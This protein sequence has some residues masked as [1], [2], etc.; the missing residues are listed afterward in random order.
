MNI[1]LEAQHAVG[2]PQPRGVGHYA[3]SLIQ[4]LL[5]RKKFNYELTY[6]DFKREVGNFE[7]AEKLF[8]K[9]NVPMHECNELDYRIASRDDSVFADKSYNEWTNTLGDVYHF[10]VPV[11][12]PTKLNGKMIVTF[13]DVSW[14][15]F[16]GFVSPNA[17]LLHDIA[18]ERVQ[19]QN[20]YIIADSESAKKEI[21]LYSSIPEERIKVIYLSYDEEQ[22]FKD[23]SS[24]ND[25]VDG[26]YILFVGT[27]EN[28]KNVVRIIEAYNMVA[29]KN[30][31]IK[32][33]LAG[34]P[35]WDNPTDIYETI[36]NSP[37]KDRII[38]PGYI[39]VEQ[40]RKL[41]SNALCFVFPSICEGFG[42]P[43][44]EAMACGCPVITADNT[45]LPEVG[46]D[47]VIYVNAYDTEQLGYEMEHVINSSNLR[48]ELIS[49]GYIQK[50]KFSWDKTA[51]HV[52]DL[53]SMVMEQNY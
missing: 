52:E 50:S 21:L 49:K 9:Y 7:R 27:F 25:I 19:R 26:D 15:A 36:N 39:T 29:E 35:T 2:H 3:T 11:S 23:K 13:H 1:V 34:K 51:E 48:E 6:F 4:T 18:L 42:I 24:V 41:Y 5:K 44:L 17:T 31:S 12:I 53:Y 46:G 33:V 40:K 30:K 8:G 38:T 16:P 14:R 37:Y 47:A 32:L 28:K 22:I 43:V 45:S 20:P 10:M